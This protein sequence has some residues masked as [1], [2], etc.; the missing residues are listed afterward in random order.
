[1]GARTLVVLA[2]IFVVAAAIRAAV[3]PLHL[4]LAGALGAP[5]AGLALIAVSALVPAGVLL[6]RVYPLLLEAPH[7][8]TALALLGAVAAV[9]GALLALA[10]RDVFRIGMFAVSSQAGLMLAAFG[11]GGYSPALFILFTGI[12]LAVRVLPR[13]RQPGPRLPQLASSPTAPAAAGACRA[14]RWRSAA[15]RW[16]SAG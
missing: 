6:A 9:G 4:W 7:V 1:M 8:L 15:G 5:V 11:M 2:V 12:F 3:G 14:P 10:Q 13:R 16:A